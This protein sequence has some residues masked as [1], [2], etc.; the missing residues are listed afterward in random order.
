MTKVDYAELAARLAPFLSGYIGPSTT[1]GSPVVP[2]PPPY[3][4]RLV[5]GGTGVTEWFPATADGFF[6]A[7]DASNDG[8]AVLVPSGT[9][10]F[11]E[12]LVVTTNIAIIGEN[13][14]TTIIKSDGVHDVLTT[15]RGCILKRFTFNATWPSSGGYAILYLEGT[16]EDTNK[17][18]NVPYV[19]D[20]VINLEI[21]SGA[22]GIDPYGYPFYWYWRQIDAYTTLAGA[23]TFTPVQ[24]V[25]VNVI[26]NRTTTLYGANGYVLI[27]KG[28]GC[29]VI[30]DNVHVSLKNGSGHATGYEM[31]QQIPEDNILEARNCS[32]NVEVASGNMARDISGF[33]ISDCNL[34]KCR[35]HVVGSSSRD[36]SG[37]EIN[38]GY[39]IIRDSDIYAEQIG[40][41]NVYGIYNYYSD[42]V[43]V[44][45]SKVVAVG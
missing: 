4:I 38:G 34:Y 39:I 10:T 44:I 42:G 17:L 25:H 9:Y 30:S 33:W 19:R 37:V 32:V 20:V 35:V 45:N 16:D 22:T 23:K 11:T 7:C 8:D 43:S 6:A 5:R 12:E 24:N 18:I 31:E 13:R 41:G 1:V 15:T 29:H 27:F 14:S 40:S 26:D 28:N 2:E 36:V 21:G 3:G